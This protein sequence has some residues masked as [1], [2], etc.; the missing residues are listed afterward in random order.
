[1]RT[2]DANLSSYKHILQR[3]ATSKAVERLIGFIKPCG[4]SKNEERK[5]SL[6][7]FLFISS[8]KAKICGES[9]NIDFLATKGL[10]LDLRGFIEAI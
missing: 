4:L 6:A 7:Q 5:L 3:R 1:V 10:F 8:K 9:L 2:T